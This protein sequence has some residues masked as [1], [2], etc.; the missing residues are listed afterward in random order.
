MSEDHKAKVIAPEQADI[1]IE[2]A[3][4]GVFMGFFTKRGRMSLVNLD[5]LA[6]AHPSPELTAWVNERREQAKE[7]KVVDAAR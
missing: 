5:R 3:D 2:V 1:R 7:M 6:A 4:D